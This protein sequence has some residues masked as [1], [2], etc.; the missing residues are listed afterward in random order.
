MSILINPIVKWAVATPDQGKILFIEGVQN[1]SH[2]LPY[3]DQVITRP[4]LID[5]N[6]KQPIQVRVVEI[7][8]HYLYH[9]H[10]GHTLVVVVS[11]AHEIH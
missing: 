9:G 3:L 4:F 7:Q 8:E 10:N 2:T 5:P 6:T 1:S 11:L